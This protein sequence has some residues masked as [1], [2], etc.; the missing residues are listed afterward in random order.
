MQNYKI[1]GRIEISW[2]KVLQKIIESG[3]QMRYKNGRTGRIVI[4]LSQ[5][6]KSELH[7]HVIGVI[8]KL[9]LLNFRKESYVWILGVILAV[10]IGIFCCAVC[11]SLK[12]SEDNPTAFAN[13][14]QAD[15]NL[16]GELDKHSLRQK[17]F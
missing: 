5:W 17:D 12:K 7:L 13:T 15:R 11:C 2:K 10:I 8:V 1:Y 16:G 6:K 3:M 9:I 4:E 14:L